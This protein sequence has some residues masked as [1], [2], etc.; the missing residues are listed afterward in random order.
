LIETGGQLGLLL[1]PVT[2]FGDKQLHNEVLPAKILSPPA[3]VG[4]INVKNS[5]LIPLAERILE[6]I[7]K[8]AN[9]DA[10]RA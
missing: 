10:H 2:C 4:F 3:P 6:R 7:C 5:T 8:T 1:A 9:S